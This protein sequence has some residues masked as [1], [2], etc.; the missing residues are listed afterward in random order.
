LIVS[1]KTDAESVRLA[2]T[3]GARGYLRKP[4]NLA[5]LWSAVKTALKQRAESAA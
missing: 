1:G 5:E 3:K 2:L 4:F